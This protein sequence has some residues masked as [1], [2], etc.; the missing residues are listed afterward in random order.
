M[1]ILSSLCLIALLL[2][3]LVRCQKID[4]PVPNSEEN[5]KIKVLSTTGIVGDLV[6][7]I[8][9]DMIDHQILIMGEIDP[10]SYEL[11]KGDDEKISRAKIIFCNGLGL[12]HG[13]SLRYSL[14]RHQGVV[15]LGDEIRKRVPERIIHVGNELD[16]HVWMD[17]ALFSHA[18]DPIVEAFV[19]SDPENQ[20]FYRENGE[21]LKKKFLE[22]DA[23]IRSMMEAVPKEKRYLVT[24]HDAFHYFTKAYLANGEEVNWEKRCAAPEGLAPDGQ[25]STADIRRIVDHLCLHQ[26][27]VVFPETNVSKDSLRKIVSSCNHKGLNVRISQDSLYGDT[28]GPTNSSAGSYLNMI[29][30]N[31]N[32]LLK[33]WNHE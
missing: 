12:E 14:Q 25:L 1:K 28:M 7:E 20:N 9:R 24:S 2:F 3:A 30:H 29:Q 17:V 10:H 18:I 15:A 16:P 21:V 33:Y 32:V 19:Q 11:V 13:A 23:K 8:G 22:T 4:F 5:K 6:K 26:I 27:S 31:A